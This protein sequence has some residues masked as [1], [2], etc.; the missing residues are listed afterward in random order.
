VAH[1]TITLLGG[2]DGTTH[3]TVQSAPLL[4]DGSVG[5]SPPPARSIARATA[6]EWWWPATASS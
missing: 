1:D 5:P 6:A 3:D 4:G 2:Y